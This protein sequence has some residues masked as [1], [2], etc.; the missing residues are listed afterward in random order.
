MITIEKASA[1]RLGEVLTILSRAELPHDGVK[2]HL[3][4]FLVARDEQG[5]MLGCAGLE[6]YG[7]LALLRSVAVVAES[8]GQG[9][10]QRLVGELLGRAARDGVEE[11]V[12]LTTTARDYFASRFGFKEAERARYDERL[13]DSPEWNLPRCSS[14]VLM[15]LRLSLVRQ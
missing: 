5:R 4:G 11:V 10:G 13:A 3:D 7:S 12:L 14:A 9:I 6:R 2:E 1:A 15:T 8:Q